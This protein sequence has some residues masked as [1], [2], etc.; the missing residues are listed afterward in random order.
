M[1]SPKY[2]PILFSAILSGLMSLVVSA[3]STMRL[4]GFEHAFVCAWLTSWLTAWTI[5]F[6]TVSVIA[7]MTRKV[8]DGLT[9][10]SP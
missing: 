2:A 4:N 7:P 8:V 3:I 6:P 1:I 9:A 5:A 10:R